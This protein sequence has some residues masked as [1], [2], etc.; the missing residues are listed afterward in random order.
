MN[1]T[2]GTISLLNT[3]NGAQNLT[4][5]PGLGSI[6][7][8]AAVGGS[9]PLTLF[10][11]IEA[12]NFT[13]QAISAA[14]IDMEAIT[15]LATMGELHTTSASGITLR[16]SSFALTGNVTTTNAGPL[17]I[18][19][20]GTTTISPSTTLTISGPFTQT[21]LG[22]TAMG[23]A[24]N[25]SATAI[26]FAGPILLNGNLALNSANGPITFGTDI[27][28]PY[29]LTI[30][31]GSGDVTA[32]V[33]ISLTNP[34]V[35]FT[36][37]SAH[38]IT[39]NGVGTTSVPLT[40]TLSLTASDIISLQSSL[41]SAHAQYYNAGNETD[42]IHTGLMTLFGS[43]GAIT[44]AG[45]TSLGSSTDLSIQSNGGSFTFNSIAGTSFENIT[46]ATGSGLATLGSLPSAGT[47]NNLTVTAGA[48]LLSGA[49]NVVNPSF[50]SQTSIQNSAT[51]V[52]IT[53]QNTAFFNA[54]NGDVGSAASL[55]LVNTPQ[56]IIAGSTYLVAFSG[57]SGAGTINIY[58]PNAPCIVIFNGVT[59][60][61]CGRPP[62]GLTPTP[63][64]TPE[65]TSSL[66]GFPAPGFYSSQFNL[67]S[68]FFFFPY[69]L[70]KRFFRPIP[71][72]YIYVAPPG[73]V[74]KF[75]WL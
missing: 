46:I 51:P 11:V 33:A 10:Q 41:Y 30:T 12:V 25:T 39:Q 20:S 36:V 1:G 49:L 18:T 55:I 59:L 50:T 73:K 28:G 21:G 3:V 7:L 54:L 64:P 45:T 66:I 57:S 14:Q 48:I 19:N 60:S 16:G 27:E 69:W 63:T 58:S 6:V 44:L 17:A 23:G 38:D 52:A 34:L 24:L 61:D 40:G 22:T 37:V 26:S 56:Q 9:T 65:S 67:A 71:F 47:I 29:S 31:G 43:G 68:D 74:M 15:G 4:F 72:T 35:N 53:S 42:F 8:S 62:P 13:S 32:P 70:D 75:W 5:D 2:T